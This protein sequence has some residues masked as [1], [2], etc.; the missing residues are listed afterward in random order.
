MK[1]VLWN[2]ISSLVVMSIF[3]GCASQGKKELTPA[4]K[5]AKLYFGQG[6]RDLVTKDYTKA[7]SNLMEAVALDPENSEIHNNLGMAYFFKNS[8]SKAQAHIKRAIQL[9]NKNTDAKLNLA[10]IY[11][12]EGKLAQAEGL[13]NEILEDLTYGGQH[14]THY[15]LGVIELSRKNQMAAKSQFN[16]SLGV[17]PNYCPAHYKLAEMSYSERNYISS[18][19]QYKEA[20]MGTCYN[21]PKPLHGQI[22]SLIQLKRY[23]DALAYLKDMQERFAMTKYESY[24]RRAIMK[25]KA[26]QAKEDKTNQFYSKNLEGE[27]KAV[28]F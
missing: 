27:R 28:D 13:Y 4:Q 14:R 7:L 16:K 17:N 15:N 10:T 26:M 19:K 2:L 25:V 24:A 12:N 8:P 3:A 5:K 1:K 9:N 11:M 21:D 23:P 20:S 6:T 22:K 18:L